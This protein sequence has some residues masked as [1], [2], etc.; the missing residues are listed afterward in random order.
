MSEEIESCPRCGFKGWKKQPMFKNVTPD[1]TPTLVSKENAHKTVKLKPYAINYI[2]AQ[3]EYSY[4]KEI[5]P[6]EK[7]G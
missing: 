6:E 2:C 5:E 1:G 7:E 4:I 3:C